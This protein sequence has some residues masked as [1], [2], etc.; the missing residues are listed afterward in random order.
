LLLR[1]P[2]VADKVDGALQVQDR[3]IVGVGGAGTSGGD[4]RV[5]RRPGGLAGQAEVVGQDVGKLFVPLGVEP[6]EDFADGGVKI[7]P[8]PSGERV[9]GGL[10]GQRVAKEVLE[11]GR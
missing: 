10:V 3:F 1:R 7:D 6:L 8:L 4:Q 11:I 5:L 2:A 9:V